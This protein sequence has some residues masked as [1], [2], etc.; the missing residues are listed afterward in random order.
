MASEIH[1]DIEALENNTVQAV[2]RIDSPTPFNVNEFVIVVCA[3]R[4]VIF[5]ACDVSRV[6]VNA[7]DAADLC[8]GTEG[9]AI[10]MEEVRR[11]MDNRPMNEGGV[12]PTSPEEVT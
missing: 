4:R 11:L 2:Y 5:A 1:T 3:H 10:T 8:I 7:K 6:V 12:R 9:K